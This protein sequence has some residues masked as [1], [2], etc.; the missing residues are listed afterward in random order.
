MDDSPWKKKK[1][2]K[3]HQNGCPVLSQ[4]SSRKQWGNK[5]YF[6]CTPY[7]SH[8]RTIFRSNMWP[9]RHPDLKRTSPN[10]GW[11]RMFFLSTAAN[12]GL[13]EAGSTPRC[14]TSCYKFYGF[15]LNNF[16]RSFIYDQLPSV[17][18]D[19][20]ECTLVEIRD[21][22]PSILGPKNRTKSAAFTP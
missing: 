14:K 2:P 8:L 4:P 11:Y 6:G 18:V 15:L 1:V 12:V 22:S 17:H 21:I 3:N 5:G 9:K 16:L 13:G 10:L 19:T 7:Q 20:N